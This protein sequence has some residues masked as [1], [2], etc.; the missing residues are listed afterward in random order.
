MGASQAGLLGPVVQFLS[1]RDP[2]R[3]EQPVTAGRQRC[4]QPTPVPTCRPLPPALPRTIPAFAS[5][6]RAVADGIAKTTDRR[7]RAHRCPLDRAPFPPLPPVSHLPFGCSLLLLIAAAAAQHAPGALA[8]PEDGPRGVFATDAGPVALGPGWKALFDPAGVT[9]VP[10]LGRAAP[11]NVP[12]R[13]TAR[14][15]A[16]DGAA[17]SFS[18]APPRAVDGTA[19]HFARAP[20]VTEVYTAT[21]HGLEQSFVLAER[22][23]GDGDLVVTCAW[24]GPAA[25]ECDGRGGLRFP[26]AGFGAITI[27]AVTAVDAAGARAAG[28]LQLSGDALTLTVPGAFVDRAVLPLVIDPLLGSALSI[29]GLG[30]EDP[31]V[32]FDPATGD[33]CYVWVDYV[34]ASDADL[35]GR[36]IS[37]ATGGIVGAAFPIEVSATNTEKPRLAAVRSSQRL[38]VVYRQP[39]GFLGSI[40][41]AARVVHVPTQAVSAAVIVAGGIGSAPIGIASED[42]TV[43]DEAIVVWGNSTD[44]FAA[45]VTVPTAGPPIP[46]APV[47]IASG[48]VNPIAT[49][50]KTNGGS[51]NYLLVWRSSAILPLPGQQLPLYCQLWSRNLA[52]VTP[53]RLVDGSTTGVPAADTSGTGWLVAYARWEPGSSTNRDIVC[54]EILYLAPFSSLVVG[55]GPT[56]VEATAAQ[57]ESAPDVAWLGQR[58]S[59]TF[60]EN[61]GASTENVGA[62]L[63]NPD[64]S[65]CGVRMSLVGVSISGW[66]QQRDAHL[67]GRAAWVAGATD[68]AVAFEQDN[69]TT[70]APLV[71]SQRLTSVG[72]GGAV[73]DLGGGCGVGGTATAGPNGFALGNQDCRF[74]V[75]GLAPGALPLCCLATPAA[76]IPCGSCT[77][78]SPVATI[79]EPNVG[80]AAVHVFQVPCD[81]ALFGFQMEVQWASLLTPTSPCPL[82]PG[83]SASNR[84]R[85]AVGQ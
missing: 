50:S 25:G 28:K 10:R 49:I 40:Q 18:A 12:L 7:D 19:V 51:G 81:P 48:L 70:P 30:Y 58:Y 55:S 35:Y 61:A 1:D 24:Q 14:G 36:R 32:V 78:L 23:A 69:P 62:R 29:A 6:R 52:A 5:L 15:I 38:L 42:T 4:T 59:V 60:T 83:L 33:W 9:F 73:V 71:I 26:I 45:E 20:G 63:V 85:F 13:L 68:G 11:Q 22:P 54:T 46:F 41:L 27:G 76:T 64:C 2:A 80:G 16:R 39:T 67:A 72:P 3:V 43:D 82:L 77:F 66:T 31:D 75:T 21:A 53:T 57:D 44:V 84:V 65:T 79:Y 56:L 17:L 47:T 74:A 8:M 34:S 37:A